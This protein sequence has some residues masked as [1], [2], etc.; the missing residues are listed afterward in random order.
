MIDTL[1]MPLFPLP[2]GCADLCTVRFLGMKPTC[3]IETCKAPRY[4]GPIE[5]KATYSSKDIQYLTT[6]EHPRQKPTLH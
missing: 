2:W 4:P 5:I 6:Q 3:H 1:M